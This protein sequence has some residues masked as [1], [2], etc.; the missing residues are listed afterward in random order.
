MN[1]IRVKVN[2]DVDVVVAMPGRVAPGGRAEQPWTRRPVLAQ[3][4]LE[5]GAICTDELTQDK[6][7]FGRTS[8]LRRLLA[9][10]SAEVSI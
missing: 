5:V 2:Q 8:H 7:R 9:A 10:A 3:H 1:V 6:A 4:P